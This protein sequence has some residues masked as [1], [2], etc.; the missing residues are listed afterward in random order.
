MAT[1]LQALEFSKPIDADGNEI[2]PSGAMTSGLT[3][4]P[5]KFDC[6]VRPRF[7]G[8]RDLVAREQM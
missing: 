6:V 3:S 7:E 1:M 2:S 5:V 4:H 8:A